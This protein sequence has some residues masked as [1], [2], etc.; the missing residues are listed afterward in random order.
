VTSWLLQCGGRYPPCVRLVVA[1]KN[2]LLEAQTTIKQKYSEAFIEQ[3]VIELL[4]RGERTVREVAVD[5]NVN[6]NTAKTG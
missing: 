1:S 6:Y 5:L 3:A 2:T 4:S